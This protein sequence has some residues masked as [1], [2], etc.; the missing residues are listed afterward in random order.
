MN[1]H[2]EKELRKE[3]QL[4]RIIFFS[5]AV[6]AII[7][8]IMILDVKL[9]EAIKTFTEA[10]AKATLIDVL[11]KLAAYIFTFY[12]V[13]GLWIKHLRMFSFL[14]GY[15]MTLVTLNLVFLLSVSL[16][17]F[18]ESF[19][20]TGG[21][22]MKYYW[23]L[24]TYLVIIY[25][26]LFTQALLVGYL[27]KNKAQLCFA[28]DNMKATLRWNTIRVNYVVV[29]ATFLLLYLTIRFDLDK[30][31][32]FYFV[33]AKVVLTRVLDFIYYRHYKAV[34][35]FPFRRATPAKPAVAHSRK[36]HIE[37]E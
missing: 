6:F 17:P 7:I 30:R 21:N 25:F 35:L 20:F 15:N 13:G 11:P 29:P 33:I 27:I 9:P 12:V 34:T 18:A 26:S 36:K 3:F 14:K 4:E 5:D 22:F 37:A 1:T 28:D 32:L 16:Y 23:G 8:T 10:Q 2:D 19:L 31:I 24:Y